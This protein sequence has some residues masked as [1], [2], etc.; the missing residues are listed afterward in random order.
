MK[1]YLPVKKLRH[2][3]YNILQFTPGKVN[4]KKF[5]SGGLVQMDRV[6]SEISFLSTDGYVVVQSGPEGINRGIQYYFKGEDLKKVLQEL[7]T[8]LEEIEVSLGDGLG[9]ASWFF[10]K[11]ELPIQGG[12]YDSEFWGSVAKILGS[13]EPV[14]KNLQL[15]LREFYLD[16]RRLQK[17][18]LIEPR[19]TYPLALREAISPY[20]QPL[21]QWKYGPELRGIISPLDIEQLVQMYPEDHGVVLW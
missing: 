5:R 16:P 14:K 18:S 17:F 21:F 7:P 3:L 11:T 8:D 15:L 10:G 9:T 13:S 2:Q 6:G 19:E 12:G 1:L 4:A 20:G